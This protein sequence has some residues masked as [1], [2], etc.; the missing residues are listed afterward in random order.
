MLSPKLKKAA[1]SIETV[2]NQI[3]EKMG[4]VAVIV[5]AAIM[6][7]TVVDVFMRGV[8][9]DPVAATTETT[10]LMMVVL[11]FLVL[12]WCAVKNKHVKIDVLVSRL[13]RKVQIALDISNHLL[14]IFVS[15]MVGWRSAVEGA[16]VKNMGITT[17]VLEIPHY[18]F[19][20]LITFGYAMLILVMINSL[21]RYI[22]KAVHQ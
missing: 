10:A 4:V 7:F 5:L 22:Y 17:S 14:V 2:I 3:S 21:V 12:A 11:V 13:P 1:H 20:Y 18:P 19:Y 9:N 6:M 16:Y 8:L 15:A